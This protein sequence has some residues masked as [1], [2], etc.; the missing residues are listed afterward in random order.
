M[1]ARDCTGAA[2]RGG[3]MGP[4]PSNAQG[5]GGDRP[6]PQFPHLCKGW[7]CRLFQ[8]VRAWPGPLLFS[9]LNPMFLLPEKLK[10]EHVQPKPVFIN[11]IPISFVETPPE[12]SGFI[13]KTSH[14]MDEKTRPGGSGSCLIS[15]KS[16]G[17][18]EEALL[19]GWA[20]A[21][22]DSPRHP[23]IQAQLGRE[24]GGEP[25]PSGQRASVSLLALGMDGQGGLWEGPAPGPASRQP[26]A[27]GR[28][29]A[30]SALKPH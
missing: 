15:E 28:G 9:H 24:P 29:L 14:P 22:G 13:I 18:Q 26:D 10:P 20:R 1:V 27:A 7:Y 21:S 2:A 30:A 3:F 25:W 17:Y 5:P 23:Y 16:R 4:G 11:L 12:N 6:W 19:G 8:S